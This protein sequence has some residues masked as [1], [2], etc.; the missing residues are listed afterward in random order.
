MGRDGRVIAEVVRGFAVVTAGIL[1]RRLFLRE[2][3]DA[4]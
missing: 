2:M 1:P 3:L 4:V